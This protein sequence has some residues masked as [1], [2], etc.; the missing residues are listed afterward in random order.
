[1][2]QLLI[3]GFHLAGGFGI[4]RYL[5]RRSAVIACYH[6]VLPGEDDSYDF[7]HANFVSAAAFERHLRWLASRYRLVPLRTIVEALEQGTELPAR[8]AA[9]TFDDGFANNYV[10]A[11][12]ILRR[13]G[14]PATI[15]LTTDKIG[16]PGEQLWTERVKRAIFLSPASTVTLTAG[17]SATYPLRTPRERERAAGIVSGILKRA[18][19][20]QRD[21][22]LEEI[23]RVCGYPS[24]QSSD[25]VRYDFLT[26]DQIR[27]M[28]ANSIGF[29][30][31]TRSHPMLR[32]LGADELTNE[33]VASKRAIERELGAEC[34]AFAYPNGKFEDFGPRDVA[35][36]RQA[37][38]RCAF[39]LEG[40]LV[41]R[42]SD[43]F[44][45]DR[46]N[47]ARQF[48]EP[49][50]NASLTGALADIRM[51]AGRRSAAPAGM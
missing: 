30:S 47:L 13:L 45:L 7:L 19:V 18:P 32:T 8:A 11:F 16:V 42:N 28:A 46:V 10:V 21:A 4:L 51:L 40:G 3:R 31:H 17:Q 39:T 37:G 29:G 5:R 14:V 41:H 9:V 44:A 35:A 43:R 49:L 24:L 22:W 15:F 27:E 34:F 6:G 12:P 25:A 2:K 23:E 50:L 38:Y 33:L 26:W 36:L 20:A 48:D 1:M